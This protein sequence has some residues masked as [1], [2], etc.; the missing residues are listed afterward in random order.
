MTYQ[1]KHQI[2]SDRVFVLDTNVLLYDWKS[3]Y[4]FTGATIVIPLIVL[5][6]L[7]KFKAESTERGRNARRVIR[8]LDEIRGHGSLS[9]GVVIKTEEGESLLRVVQSSPDDL[10]ISSNDNKIIAAVGSLQNAGSKVTFISKDINARVK[11][12]L[13]GFEAEAGAVPAAVAELLARRSEARTAKEWKLS[14]T[15]RD[16]I[17]AAGWIVKDTK[18]GQKLTPAPRSAA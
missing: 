1:N 15:L 4:A 6:E 3:L 14:D 13:L 16:E 9:E 18:E 7:D 5:E 8:V 17:L 11:T 10:S 12:D 2:S